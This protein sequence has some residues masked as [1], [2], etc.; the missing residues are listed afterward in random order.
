MLCPAVSVQPLRHHGGYYYFFSPMLLLRLATLRLVVTFVTVPMARYFC[1]T[2]SRM[3]LRHRAGG[4]VRF[5]EDA[6][7]PHPAVCFTLLR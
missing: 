3:A 7:P 2:V 1:F 4:A 5:S 6:T